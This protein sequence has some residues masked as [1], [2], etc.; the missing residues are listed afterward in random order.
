MSYVHIRGDNFTFSGQ[1]E[2][3]EDG[4]PL[5][6]LVGWTGE[7]QVRRYD[8][9]LVET[10]EFEWLDASQR[11]ASLSSTTDTSTWPAGELFLHCRLT[12]SSGEKI[13]NNPSRFTCVI[14]I[15]A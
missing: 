5:T 1:L 13:S 11:L 8:N 4:V 3:S 7:A 6:S 2:V 12:S 10:L 15:G 14:G 9:T